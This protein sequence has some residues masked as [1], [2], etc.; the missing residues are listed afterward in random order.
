MFKE[1]FHK[2]IDTLGYITFFVLIWYAIFGGKLKIELY[3]PF[4]YFK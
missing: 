4:R 1:L 3:N 2:L